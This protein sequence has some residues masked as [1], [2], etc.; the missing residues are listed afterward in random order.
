[1]KFDFLKKTSNL[2][3]KEVN[4]SSSFCCIAHTRIV[5]QTDRWIDDEQTI[6]ADRLLAAKA[7]SNDNDLQF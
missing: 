6:V 1:M 4:R 7:T 2:K 3:K 5:F